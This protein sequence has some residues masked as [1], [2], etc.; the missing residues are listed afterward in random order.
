[1]IRTEVIQDLLDSKIN[2]SYLEIGVKRG[3]NFFPIKAAKKTAVDP[4]F[5]FPFKTRF[6][7]MYKN[8]S[9]LTARYYEIPS[10][11]YF[12]SIGKNRGMD[13]VFIDGLHTYEQSL[14]DVRNALEILNKGGVIV[15]H[16]CNPPHKAAA[17]PST[18][19]EE[20]VAANMDGWTGEW[21]G[22]VWKT[23]CHLR[24]VQRDV[25]AFVLD[26]DYGLGIVTR[27]D[28]DTLLNLTAGQVAEMTYDDLA[29]N[30]ET[31]IGLKPETYFFDFLKSL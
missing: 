10:D 13:V 16:D 14:K 30:R 24:S 18:T 2:P 6:R 17:Y 26:C 23:I 12:T 28:P 4:F 21:C 3:E 5:D 9:N 8:P 29:A 31:L 25:R 11:D 19:K 7:W 22:D 20:A 27:S 1:M 15:M